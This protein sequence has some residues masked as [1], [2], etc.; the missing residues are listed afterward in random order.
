MRTFLISTLALASVLAVSS[1][2]NA[3]YWLYGVYYPVCYWNWFGQ[4]V[5]F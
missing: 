1:A 3:G 2:A 4:Y 5:C